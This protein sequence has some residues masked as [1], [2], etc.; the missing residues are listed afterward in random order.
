MQ[1]DL[2]N[3]HFLNRYL[4]DFVGRENMGNRGGTAQSALL[5]YCDR[6]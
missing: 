2:D 4:E 6:Q 5:Q 3:D 1:R